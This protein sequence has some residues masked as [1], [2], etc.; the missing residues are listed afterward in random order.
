[1][2][3]HEIF[4]HYSRLQLSRAAVG[5]VLFLNIQCAVQFLASPQITRRVLNF[6]EHGR[7]SYSRYGN[8]I[9]YVECALCFCLNPPVKYRISYFQAVIMQF[10]GLLGE[11]FLWIV[12]PSENALIAANISRFIIFDGTGLVF[13]TFGYLL[14]NKEYTHT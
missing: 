9:P 11:T 5:I 10:I 2:S 1:M 12:I 7:N 4:S 13:M 3:D 14:I 6:Q 8:L